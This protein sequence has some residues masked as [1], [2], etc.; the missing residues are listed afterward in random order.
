MKAA[1]SPPAEVNAEVSGCWSNDRFVPGTPSPV[2][3]S[4]TAVRLANVFETKLPAG[5]SVSRKDEISFP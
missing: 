3:V 4:T 2:I 1:I 5:D